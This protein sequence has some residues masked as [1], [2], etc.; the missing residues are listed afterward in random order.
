MGVKL[1]KSQSVFIISHYEHSEKEC[2][3]MIKYYKT[4][5]NVVTEIN[6]PQNGCWISVVAP[7][8]DEVRY[9]IEHFSLDA[10]FVRASL[11]EE[12]N[13]RVEI[14]EDQ[15]LVIVDYAVQEA[16]SNATNAIL[17]YTLPMGIIL[18]KEHV[19]TISIKENIILNELSSGMIKNVHTNLKTR[20]IFIILLRIAIKFLQFLKQIDKLSH[21]VEKNL[22]KSMKNKEL[23]QLLDLEKS[24]VYF[25]TSLKAN[26]VTLEKILRGRVIKLYEEDQDLLEDVLIEIKQAIEMSEIYSSILSG[27]MDA[28][29]SIIS[30]NLNIVMKRLT[31]ITILMAVPT[32]VFSYYGMNVTNLPI[33]TNWFPIIVAIII[34]SIVAYAMLKKD[35]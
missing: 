1:N 10:G 26:E 3:I 7:D 15:T 6:A 28:F 19:V 2:I 35:K 14:E 33:A 11:D 18:T 5:N 21:I 13:S 4:L 12:E 31:I 16:D 8:E 29:A 34:T 32:I 30:N 20:F 25:S 27:M 17:Y 9:I 23:I 22:H 24:L